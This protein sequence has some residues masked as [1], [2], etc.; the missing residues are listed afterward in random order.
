MVNDREQK[1]VNVTIHDKLNLEHRD[2]IKPLDS[3]NQEFATCEH[4]TAQSSAVTRQ[5]KSNSSTQCLY[6]QY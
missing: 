2:V 1:T 4:S 3:D 6:L 5:Y